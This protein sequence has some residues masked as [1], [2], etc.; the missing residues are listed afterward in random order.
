M[1]F[2]GVEKIIKFYRFSKT[3]RLFQILLK[4]GKLKKILQQTLKFTL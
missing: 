3:K 2:Y 4:G 1:I